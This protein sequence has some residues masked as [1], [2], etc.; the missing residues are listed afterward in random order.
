MSV[1]SVRREPD[2]VEG[3][4]ESIQK[5]IQPQKN[6]ILIFVGHIS[7]NGYCDPFIVRLY[8]CELRQRREKKPRGKTAIGAPKISSSSG[9]ETK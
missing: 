4:I 1:R 8:K 2:L 3:E 5:K 7:V 9:H 6:C